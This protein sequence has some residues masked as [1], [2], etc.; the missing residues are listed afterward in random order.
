MSF[1]STFGVSGDVHH[2]IGYKY[3]VDFG[4]KLKQENDAEELKSD[5]E[6]P[7]ELLEGDTYHHQSQ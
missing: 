6:E 2:N 5:Q 4:S 3:D 1:P 7:F